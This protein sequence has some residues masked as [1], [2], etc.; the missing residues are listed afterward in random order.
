M[1][2]SAI[3]YSTRM[4]FSPI[5]RESTAGRR[6]RTIMVRGFRTG[7][8]PEDLHGRNK[9]FWMSSFEGYKFPSSGFAQATMATEAFKRGDLSALLPTTIIYDPLTCKSGACQPFARNMI[10]DARISR[11]SKKVILCSRRDRRAGE[12]SAEHHAEPDRR[13]FLYHQG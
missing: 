6:I 4:T 3:G 9:V 1:S 5:G 13:A 11:V 10:P 12:Q 2:S 7:V 8:C